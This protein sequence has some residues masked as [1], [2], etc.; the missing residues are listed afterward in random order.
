MSKDPFDRKL[1]S[2]RIA[3]NTRVRYSLVPAI[4]SAVETV[5]MFASPEFDAAVLSTTAPVS[6]SS[7]TRT[8][9]RSARDTLN[10]RANPIVSMPGSP[11]SWTRPQVSTTT[12]PRAGLPKWS[13]VLV[14]NPALVGLSTCAAVAAVM[15]AAR[16]P[17]RTRARRARRKGN[18]PLL[19]VR[20]GTKSIPDQAARRRGRQPGRRRRDGELWLGPAEPAGTPAPAG[21]PAELVTDV[22]TLMRLCSGRR[23][24]PSRFRLDGATPDRYLLFR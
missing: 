7:W 24:D 19:G 16:A 2:Q 23:P 9:T 11:T 15:P 1:S 5:T 10:A 3:Q 14:V 12:V 20:E 21:G 13:K 18:P 22:A 4:R 17:T 8:A 6:S